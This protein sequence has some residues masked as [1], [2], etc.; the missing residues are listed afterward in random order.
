FL[1]FQNSTDRND[2]QKVME[3]LGQL[4]IIGDQIAHLNRQVV[5]ATTEGGPVRVPAQTLTRSASF[6]Q[7]AKDQEL[8]ISGSFLNNASIEDI[9]KGVSISPPTIGSNGKS[10]RAKVSVDDAAAPGKYVL[11]IITPG[12]ATPF[13]LNIEQAP[14]VATASD[15][16]DVNPESVKSPLTQ[17]ALQVMDKKKQRV[18][19]LTVTGKHLENAEVVGNDNVQVLEKQNV[20]GSKLELL[21]LAPKAAGT[22]SVDIKNK[23]PRDN[24]KTVSFDLK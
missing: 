16:K 14:P 18:V 7:G 2:P 21:L 12:G 8:L 10:L 23:S 1:K 9:P 4:V 13:T 3:Q 20:D 19:K 5:T 15:T 17:A 11:A 6:E 22:Y 24:T